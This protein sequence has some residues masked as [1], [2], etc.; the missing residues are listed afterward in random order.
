MYVMC[1]INTTILSSLRLTAYVVKVFA[2][3]NNLVAVPSNII[4]DAVKFLILNT[5]QPDGMFTEV[6]RVYSSGMSVRALIL[7]TSILQLAAKNT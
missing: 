3:A 1:Q 6:G 4:C 7:L 5:Q 2:M